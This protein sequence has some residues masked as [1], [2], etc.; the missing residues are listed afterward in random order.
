MIELPRAALTAGQIA[1]AAQFFS[2]GTNDLTQTTWGF[3]RDDVEAAFFSTYLEMG[4]FGASPFET[5]DKEGVGELVATAR[6]DARPA[7]TSSSGCAG[8]TAATRRRCTSS[9]RQAWTTCPARRS[10]SRSLAWRRAEWRSRPQ[11]VQTAA[12]GA[13]PQPDPV[14]PNEHDIN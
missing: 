2:F 6:A 10:G 1:E 14:E 9:T 11:P 8:N 7:P 3:S 13:M 4:I 5:M 12:D